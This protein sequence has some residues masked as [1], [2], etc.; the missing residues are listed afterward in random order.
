MVVYSTYQRLF[1]YFPTN[2]EKAYRAIFGKVFTGLVSGCVISVIFAFF[3]LSGK[4][5]F[6]KQLLYNALKL[7]GNILNVS[8]YISAVIPSSPGAFL[9]FIPCFVSNLFSCEFPVIWCV[10]RSSCYVSD[11][12]MVIVVFEVV[13]FLGEVF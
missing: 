11:L 10:S 8:F 5:P 12:F 2:I 9:L 13:V 6:F 3:H 7:F 4:S 1:K